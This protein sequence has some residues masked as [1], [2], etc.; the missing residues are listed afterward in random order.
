MPVI[1]TAYNLVIF[2]MLTMVPPSSQS[3]VEHFH[4]PQK[5]PYPLAVSPHSPASPRQS[6]ICYPSVELAYSRRFI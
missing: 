5:S 1:H 2:N 3:V 6:L 4:Y